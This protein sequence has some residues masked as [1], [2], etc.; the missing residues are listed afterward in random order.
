MI[1]GWLKLLSTN[2]SYTNHSYTNHSYT[3][4]SYTNHSYTNHSYTNHSYTNHLYLTYVLI[5]MYRLSPWSGWTGFLSS[6]AHWRR[7]FGIWLRE[8][9][10]IL[11]RKTPCLPQIFHRRIERATRGRRLP[12]HTSPW[13]SPEPL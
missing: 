2:H 3:N 11:P 10:Q 5:Y 1:Y 6:V 7:Y 4:H 8:G 13:F 12:E 9:S